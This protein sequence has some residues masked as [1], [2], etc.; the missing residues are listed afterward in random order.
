MTDMNRIIF[1]DYPHFSMHEFEC[2]CCHTVMLAPDLVYYFEQLRVELY[3]HLGFEVPVRIAS[4]YRCPMH[5]AKPSI[6]GVKNSFHTQGKAGDPYAPGVSKL[7]VA[8]CA[9]R[10]GF[11]RVGLYRKTVTLPK[12][13]GGRRTVSTLVLHCDLGDPAALGTRRLFGDGWPAGYVEA[14]G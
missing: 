11:P 13:G 5:N 9:D 10:A 4:G 3:K 2:P 6:R 12:P 14:H 1:R 8:K 7:V